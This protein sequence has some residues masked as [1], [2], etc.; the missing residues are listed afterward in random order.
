[1]E[2]L[3]RIKARASKIASGIPCPGSKTLIAKENGSFTSIT[4]MI[5]VYELTANFHLTVSKKDYCCN[6][7]STEMDVLINFKATDRTDFNPG[8]V[9]GG[10]GITIEDSLIIACNIGNSF[11]ISAHS[12]EIFHSVLEHCP[13]PLLGV[14]H[15]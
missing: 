12:T 9:F 8:D 15:V 10:P 7:C 6:E 3:A 14:Y 13:N 4:K 1:M 5:N 11:D 2:L